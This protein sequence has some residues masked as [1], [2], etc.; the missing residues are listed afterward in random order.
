MGGGYIISVAIPYKSGIYSN[1]LPCD[2]TGVIV[3][4]A[5]PYK[6]GIYSN[7]KNVRFKKD[8]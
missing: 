6:S 4:V 3:S 8:L 1:E 7:E 5:I 2:Y